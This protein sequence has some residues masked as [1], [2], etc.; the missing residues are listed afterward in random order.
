[1]V[2][3]ALPALFF[4][5]RWQFLL[6]CMRTLLHKPKSVHL[7]VLPYIFCLFT[8]PLAHNNLL[9]LHFRN[10]IEYTILRVHTAP[11]RSIGP[12]RK[13]SNLLYFSPMPS[14]HSMLVR[15]LRFPSLDY[16]SRSS[17]ADLLFWCPVDSNP[18]LG[19]IFHLV[20][21]SKYDQP[22]AIYVF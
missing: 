21:S 15:C 16:F 7:P 19:G 14:L 4:C 10:T 2:V 1:M 22:I 17:L 3:C 6:G 18:A 13:L 5:Y 9:L 11:I 20:P 12:Q 8:S